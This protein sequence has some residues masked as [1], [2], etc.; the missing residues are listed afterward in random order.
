MR[1]D[2]ILKWLVEARNTIVK[3]GDLAT[4]STMKVAVL[5]SYY[6][7]PHVQFDVPASVPTAK[8]AKQIDLGQIPETIRKD[9]ILRVERRW[10][11]SDL[12]EHELLSALSHAFDVLNRL[13]ADADAQVG[14]P[15]NIEGPLPCMEDISECLAVFIEMATGERIDRM[16]IRQGCPSAQQLASAE[17]RYGGRQAQVPQGRTLVEMARFYF[18][19]AKRVLTTDGYHSQVVILSTKT[20]C[21]ILMRLEPRNQADKYLMWR[22][23]AN[24]VARINA[25]SLVTICEVWVAPPDPAQ[26]DLRAADSPSRSEGL[27]LVAANAQGETISIFC[28]FERKAG[29]IILGP[30]REDRDME[31]NFLEPVQAVWQR[32]PP[33]SALGGE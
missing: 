30:E 7:L 13:V 20:R 2:P 16:L 9:G 31:M 11:C 28:P 21:G 23:V 17:S 5:A 4:K 26:P 32:R 3:K 18:D 27:Q 15:H 22:D 1:Q 29:K 6:E 10:I 33:K 12:P 14:T 19:M 8:L 24:E 25:E